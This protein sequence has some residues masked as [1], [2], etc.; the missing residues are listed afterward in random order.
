MYPWIHD[1]GI[2][3]T[4]VKIC[5]QD[6]I[7]NAPDAA[8][9]AL[10]KSG[11]QMTYE[12]FLDLIVEEIAFPARLRSMAKMVPSDDPNIMHLNKLMARYDA[13]QLSEELRM[14][15]KKLAE[16][17]QIAAEATAVANKATAAANTAKQAAAILAALCT[18]LA[19]C[20][21]STKAV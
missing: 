12:N 6:G 2:L 8:V 4:P 20:M 16:A 14:L 21:S 13:R 15:T 10:Q 3:S 5:F 17:E 18:E 9:D 7:E 11:S 1:F 19:V